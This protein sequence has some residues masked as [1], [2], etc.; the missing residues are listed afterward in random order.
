MKPVVVLR[1]T[2]H[3][4][5]G[6]VAAVLA[7]AGLRPREVDL[8]AEVPRQLPWDDSAGLIVLGGPM[9]VND[10]DKHPFLL[11][12]LDW[13]RE[14]VEREVPTLGVCLGAQLLA[15]ALGQR[16][17]ANRRKEIGWFEIE[18]LP[19]AADDRLFAG[20]G[21]VE[22]VFH[23]HGDTFDLP[24]GA[25]HLARGNLCPNQAFRVGRSAYGLQ[26]HVEMT[27]E[28]MAE[29][30]A[31]PD[32]HSQIGDQADP[33]AIRAE[34]PRRFPAMSAWS[35]CLLSRFAALC[36]ERAAGR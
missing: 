17:Y 11:R 20:R 2:P 35:G 1:H 21:P 15:K 34:A 13:L 25:V 14:A 27:P 32:L 28:L 23:W 36:C 9:S 26:F 3:C 19:D 31:E 22:T 24:A 29:W 7:E 18:L 4:P 12:E 33:Q 10:T 6:S 16:V 5:L 8:F 30:F